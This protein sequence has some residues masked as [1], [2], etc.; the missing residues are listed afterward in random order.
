MQKETSN[1]TG[2]IAG[3]IGAVVAIAAIITVVVFIA[4]KSAPDI[5][6]KW[7]LDTMIE[8]GMTFD[9]AKLEE[10]GVNGTIEF[11]DDGTGILNYSDQGAKK[12]K[13][14]KEKKEL[15]YSGEK[16]KYTFDGSKLVI[17]MDAEK[18]IMKFV[19]E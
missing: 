16:V 14:D 11:K 18:L 4:S 5:I 7:K 13:Y 2:L 1:K 3:I 17:D 10:N 12:F 8:E 15:D 19:K 6:G 9:S